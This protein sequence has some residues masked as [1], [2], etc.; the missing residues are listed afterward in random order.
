M[1]DEKE[2]KNFAALLIE[3]YSRQKKA[4]KEPITPDKGDNNAKK[5]V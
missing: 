5:E 2:E 1:A 3:W 4:A